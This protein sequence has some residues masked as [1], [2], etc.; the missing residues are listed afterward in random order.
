MSKYPLNRHQN[1]VNKNKELQIF[2]EMLLNEFVIGY[3][4]P[5]QYIKIPLSETPSMRKITFLILIN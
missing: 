5:G 1:N 2:N 4:Q 3:K